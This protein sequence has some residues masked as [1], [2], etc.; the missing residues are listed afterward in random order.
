MKKDRI[1]NE[2]NLIVQFKFEA[3]W[4]K[5]NLIQLQLV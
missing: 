2:V 1:I 4:E 3:I 5:Y